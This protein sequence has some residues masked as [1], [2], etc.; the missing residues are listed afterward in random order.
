MQDGIRQQPDARITRAPQGL[1][2][3]DERTAVVVA[4]SLDEGGVERAA[5]QSLQ[6]LQPGVVKHARHGGPLSRESHE[7]GW[8]GSL[9]RWRLAMARPHKDQLR[10]LSD[11]ESQWLSHVSQSRMAPMALVQRARLL[12]EVAAGKSYTDAAAPTR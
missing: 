7:V 12:L 11:E 10:P 9:L 4:H 1:V 2:G 8:V 3:H 5:L 6:R